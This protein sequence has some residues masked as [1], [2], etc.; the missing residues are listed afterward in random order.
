MTMRQDRLARVFELFNFIRLIGRPLYGALTLGV[1]IVLFLLVTAQKASLTTHQMVVSL[2]QKVRFKIKF[3]AIRLRPRFKPS[4]INPQLFTVQVK[5][6]RFRL[7]LPKY[8]LALAVIVSGILLS[9]YYLILKDLPSPKTLVE[10]RPPATTKILARDGQLLYKIFDGHHNRTLVSLNDLP[11]HVI[12]STLAIEDSEFFN[13]P[14]FSIRGIVRAFRKNITENTM[15][16]GSTITQ[17]LVKLALLRDDSKTFTR[18]I[19]EVILALQIEQYFTKNEILTMYLNQVG[20]GGTNYGIEEAAQYFFGK[21]AK[22]VNLAEAAL[23]AGLPQAPTVYSPYGTQPHLAVYRQHE[24]LR[25]MVEE[26]YIDPSQAEDAKTTSLVFDTPVTNINAPHFVMFVKDH[27]VNRYSDNVVNQAGLTV[28]TSLDLNIQHLAE[29]AVAEELLKLK[30]MNVKNAA[31]MVTRP[32]TGEVLAMVGSQN[33]FDTKNDGQVNVALRERQPGSAI[34]VITYALALENGMTAS[35]IIDDTPVTYNIPG[36]PPY[37]PK[38]YDGEYHGRVTLRQALANSYNIPAVKTLS[39]VGISNMIDKAP[40]MGISSWQD[41]SRYGLSLTLGGGDV[42]MI[43]MAVAFG[44]IANYGVRINLNPL[45][46]IEDYTHRYD[47]NLECTTTPQQPGTVKAATTLCQ[48]ALVIKPQAAFILSDILSDNNARARE[49]G[50]NSVLNIKGHQVAVK[51]GT[52]NSLRDNWTIGYTKDYLV[53]VWVGNNDNSPMS[54]VVSGITGASPIWNKIMTGLLKDKPA[55]DFTPP[56]GVVE[57]SVCPLTSSLS[58][59]ECPNSRREYYI[60]GTQPRR[61]CTPEII[62]RLNPQTTPSASPENQ[63]QILEGINTQ[64]PFMFPNDTRTFAT[65]PTPQSNPQT[66]RSNP[67]PQPLQDLRDRL[68]QRD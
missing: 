33:F 15:Q 30:N 12:Q 3:P 22:E 38:N 27:L 45:L 55:H 53:A 49:F 65:N 67:R 66:N 9:F 10:Y 42:R 48:G 56:P 31:V 47:A 40:A 14:G 57:V 52:T 41:R 20:Y 43:D 63:D 29:K 2:R 28:T 5:V 19:R 51:T 11:A 58:C 37:S 61:S 59:A 44:S 60:E 68:R 62:E 50:T 36:S 13:H 16:G 23:L 21:P 7:I 35:T 24:V 46:K 25:R 8:L 1:L 17:Q 64:I 32:G 18:K 6:R 4:A 34:K 54:R 26:G 39:Q